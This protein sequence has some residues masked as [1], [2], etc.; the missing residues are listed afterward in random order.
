VQDESEGLL[1]RPWRKAF[2]YK[3]AVAWGAAA[4]YQVA[5]PLTGNFSTPALI[6]AVGCMGMASVNLLEA[7][8]IWKRRL[9]LFE[10]NAMFMSREDLEDRVDAQPDKIYLGEGWEWTP[11]HSQW[12]YDLSRI[13]VGTLAPPSWY[14]CLVTKLSDNE[15]QYVLKKPDDETKEKTEAISQVQAVKRLAREQGLNVAEALKQYAES[16]ERKYVPRGVPWV[17]GMSESSAQYVPIEDCKGNTLISG[18]TRSGKTVLYRLLTSQI[19]RKRECLIVVDPKGDLDLLNLMLESAHLEGR[20]DDFVFFHPAF[21]EYSSRIDPLANFQTPSQLASRI[22]PLIPASSTNGDNFSKFA[23]GV[24]E[25]IFGAMDMLNMRPSLMALRNVIERGPEDLLYDCIVKHCERINY[26]DYLSSIRSWENKMDKAAQKT[27]TS[28]KVLGAAAFYKDEVK[29]FKSDTAIDGLLG[30][31][32]HNREHASKM[33]AG[34][35]PILKSLTTG[36]LADLLS[37]D[38]RDANDPR[39]VTSLDEL[40]KRKSIAYIGLDAMADPAVAQAIGSIYMSDLV[41]SAAQRYTHGGTG[42]HD[43]FLLID[44][45]SNAVNKSVIELL[46]KGAGAGF[47]VFAA[48][49]TV[50]DFEDALGN[51]S[52]KDKTLGNFNNHISLRVIDE[53]TKEF[54]SAQMGEVS[55]RT[56]QISQNTQSLGSDH[57]PALYSGGYGSRTTD[58]TAPKIEPSLLG[59][60]P[61]L[62]CIAHI[63]AGKVLKCRL[64][65]LTAK[66][67]EESI[68]LNDLPWVKRSRGV[69][70]NA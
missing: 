17:H 16:V 25:S 69:L 63:S 26:G 44:E 28:A 12:V 23:W 13:D 59:R 61:D 19:I 37:P 34:L 6:A 57:N 70:E 40:I 47:R 41:A 35:M 43:V 58:S 11:D 38:Q 8:R 49:Q 22:E 27:G 33:L 24:M 9:M 55:V 52:T 54:V 50:P 62:E 31:F 39:P 4:A 2:E 65:L 7:H 48:T 29:E 64:P 51:A 67:G 1:V 14:V 56:A 66:G 68:G 53:A 32:E 18:T 45:A 20:L 15:K 36:P 42:T 5:F 30:F 10:S 21:S 60:L 3:A 46:N